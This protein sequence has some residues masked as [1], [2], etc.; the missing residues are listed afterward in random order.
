VQNPPSDYSAGHSLLGPAPDPYEV[1]CGWDECALIDTEGEVVFGTQ[2]YKAAGI[3]V[4]D[5]DY[6]PV[7]DRKA[8]LQQRG[9]QLVGLMAEMSAFLR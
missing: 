6:R 7:T 8:V 9:Q 1:S 3:D 4:L 5:P 2:A